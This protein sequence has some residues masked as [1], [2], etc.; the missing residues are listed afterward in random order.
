M[1]CV[2]RLILRDR[3]GRVYREA[4]SF[5]IASKAPVIRV[6]LAQTRVRAGASVHLRVQ[7]SA[8]TRT[9]TARLSGAGPVWLHWNTAERANTGDIVVPAQ[10]PAGIYTVQV[11]GEDMAHNLGTQEVRLE[12]V[13]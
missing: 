1:F 5:V 4:K 6:Q 11:I 2:V 7:A 3:Q 12:V 10:L 8:S 9:L 13:P